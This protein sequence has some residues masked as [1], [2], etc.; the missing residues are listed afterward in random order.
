MGIATLRQL[1]CSGCGNEVP[2][3]EDEINP[4]G[5]FQF[6]DYCKTIDSLFKRHEGP[7]KNEDIATLRNKSISELT[8]IVTS[9]KVAKATE[10]HVVDKKAICHLMLNNSL[11]AFD[12]KLTAF[13]NKVKKTLFDGTP[14]LT[15]QWS[16]ATGQGNGRG[17]DGVDMGD[18][19][20]AIGSAVAPR[21]ANGNRVISRDADWTQVLRD[22]RGPYAGASSSA[23]GAGA[24]AGAAPFS[25]VD[26]FDMG[27]D[28]VDMGDGEAAFGS[29]VAPRPAK[30][31]TPQRSA[32]SVAPSA[33]RGKVRVA[34]DLNLQI[35]CIV[36][37]PS[38]PLSLSLPS[39]DLYVVCVLLCVG[40]LA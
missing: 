21:L 28:G 12:I 7:S 37:E 18:G 14:H 20:P 1:V 25:P 36:Y 33:A 10:K 3:S 9:V 2:K 4:T 31:Q 16:A 17:G 27:G 23:A 38:L 39:I 26:N 30:G 34:S 35:V 15:V 11:D 8:A 5:A 40:D 22:A 13:G 19:E 32:P 29:A 6:K 24:G